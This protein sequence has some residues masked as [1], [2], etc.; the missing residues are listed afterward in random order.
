[1]TCDKPFD[2]K[3]RIHSTSSLVKR[4]LSLERPHPLR[5][6]T[7]QIVDEQ[8]RNLRVTLSLVGFGLLGANR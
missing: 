1:M 4:P 6:T 3:L 7:C 2:P 8:L 5:Q